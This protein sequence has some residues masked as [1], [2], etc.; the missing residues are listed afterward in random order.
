MICTCCQ[1][2]MLLPRVVVVDSIAALARNDTERHVADQQQLLGIKW[3]MP[4]QISVPLLLPTA[5]L[6]SVAAVRACTHWPMSN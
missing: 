2:L 1:I 3:P 4:R 5:L 6:G